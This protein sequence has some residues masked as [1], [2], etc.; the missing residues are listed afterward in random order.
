MLTRVETRLQFASRCADLSRILCCNVES[1]TRDTK[2]VFVMPEDKTSRREKARNR[3]LNLFHNASRLRLPVPGFCQ[4]TSLMMC[5]QLCVVDLV[6][7]LCF[8]N[9]F[10]ISPFFAWECI[11]K[12]T[13]LTG[14]VMY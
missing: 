1:V 13:T 7:R 14:I 4:P 9:E 11:D 6:A 5:T 10:W 2:Y 3:Y 12:H 8:A